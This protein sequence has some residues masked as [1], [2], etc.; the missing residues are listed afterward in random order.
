MFY[1]NIKKNPRNAP[2]KKKKRNKQRLNESGKYNDVLSAKYKKKYQKHNANPTKETNFNNTAKISR[3]Q[4]R[5]V[6]S[7]DPN[8]FNGIR[9]PPL[10]GNVI[11]PTSGNN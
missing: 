4:H 1:R 7:R 6:N 10:H 11:P 9:I 5:S 3:G 8:Y 2:T